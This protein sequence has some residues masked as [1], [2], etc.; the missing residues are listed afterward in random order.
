MSRVVANRRLKPPFHPNF[1]FLAQLKVALFHISASLQ[2]E[3]F[4]HQALEAGL[5]EEIVG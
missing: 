1:V 5:V 4:P 2:A 3:A